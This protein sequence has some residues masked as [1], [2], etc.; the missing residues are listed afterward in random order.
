MRKYVHTADSIGFEDGEAW[1]RFD[2]DAEGNVS[3]D[4]SM[5]ITL[6]REEVAKVLGWLWGSTQR[7]TNAR[8]AGDPA[9]PI[10]PYA[11]VMETCAPRASTVGQVAD[12]RRAARK[13]AK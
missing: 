9:R 6:S 10:G 4:K 11:K 7:R 1:V 2:R 12:I 5:D 8:R 3:I 13:G